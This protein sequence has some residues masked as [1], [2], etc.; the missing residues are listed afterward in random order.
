MN[1]ASNCI[2]GEYYDTATKKCLTCPAGYECSLSAKTVCPLGTKYDSTQARCI[3]CTDVHICVYD[4]K[5][6]ADSS[7][8]RWCYGKDPALVTILDDF[9]NAN[10]LP[11][12]DY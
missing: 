3:E 9:L 2:M 5:T 8:N 12:S 10:R 7:P 11:A 6:G 4:P 1:V